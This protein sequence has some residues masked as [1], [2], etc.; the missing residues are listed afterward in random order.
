MLQRAA[1]GCVSRESLRDTSKRLT[2]PAGP[3]CVS[4]AEET[5]NWSNPIRRISSAG[6]GDVAGGV[7]FGR[8]ARGR[9]GGRE[10]RGEGE[11]EGAGRGEGEG[12]G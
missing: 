11:G 9:E 8:G 6:Q 4:G 7:L 12:E 10:R 2:R 1:L 3:R 5:Q